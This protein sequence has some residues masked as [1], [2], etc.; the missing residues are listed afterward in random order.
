MTRT[1]PGIYQFECNATAQLI[2]TQAADTN[3]SSW[4][5]LKQLTQIQAAD[6]NA[7]TW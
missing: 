4:H 1:R 2:Q 7:S 3:S 5:K 6:T